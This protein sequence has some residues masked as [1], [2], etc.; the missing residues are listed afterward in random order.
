M[1]ERTR[2]ITRIG[3]V[4]GWVVAIAGAGV[5]AT[6]ALAQSVGDPWGDVNDWF[7]LVMVVALAPLMLSFYELGGRTPLRLAQL[8]QLLGWASVITWAVLQ[9][10]LIFNLVSFEM[11]TAASGWFAVGSLALG[12]V[13]LWIAG[14]NLLAGPWLPSIRWVGV[15]AGLAMTLFA[16]G[17]LRGGVDSGWTE[18]GGLGTA[19]LIPIWAA[20]MARLLTRLSA[21]A[22]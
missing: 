16:F 6:V 8:A 11:D 20:L 18:L 7:L 1:S 21:P 10:L 5:L 4:A 3:T 22:A 14:A 13:G 15:G 9:K 12:Y 17:L 2:R 19:V